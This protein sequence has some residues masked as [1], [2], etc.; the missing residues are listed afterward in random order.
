MKKWTSTAVMFLLI[1][2]FVNPISART[3]FDRMDKNND[4][5]LTR[6]EYKGPDRAF[7][8]PKSTSW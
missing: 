6:S 4:G 3:P 7:N 1:G 5:K 2:C 8:L